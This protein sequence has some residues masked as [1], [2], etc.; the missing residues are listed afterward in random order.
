M[1]FFV[2]LLIVALIIFIIVNV[3]KKKSNDTREVILRQWIEKLPGNEIALQIEEELEELEDESYVV[4]ASSI[5]PEG[6]ALFTVSSG[7]EVIGEME[8]THHLDNLS[9]KEKELRKKNAE[10]DTTQQGE[11]YY[12]IKNDN[13]GLLVYST[14]KSKDLPPFLRIAAKLIMESGYDFV[15]PEWLSESPEEQKYFNVMFVKDKH[16]LTDLKF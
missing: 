8:C 7:S 15:H 16:G 14:V 1:G 13:I 5:T 6:T 3:A 10:A 2:F 9:Y 11:Y 12:A 4:S